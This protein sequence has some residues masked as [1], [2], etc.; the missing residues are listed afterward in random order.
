MRFVVKIRWGSKPPFGRRNLLPTN[1]TKVY[2]V[3]PLPRHQEYTSYGRVYSFRTVAAFHL[4]FHIRE[5]LRPNLLTS[6]ILSSSLPI[7]GNT[8]KVMHNTIKG[9]KVKQVK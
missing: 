1:L 4:P 6:L 9:T 2:I 3:Q 7:D 8:I 5:I